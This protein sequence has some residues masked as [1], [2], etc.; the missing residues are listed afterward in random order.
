MTIRSALTTIETK[1]NAKSKTTVR[2]R[3]FFATVICSFVLHCPSVSAA[4]SAAGPRNEKLAEIATMARHNEKCPDIPRQWAV[5]YLILLMMHPP[6]EEQVTIEE[7]KTLA[8]R[9][10][11]G[12]VKW[13]QLYSVE[14]QQAYLI[15]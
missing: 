7:R 13:C 2:P 6:T 15:Y 5:A 9:R 1:P 8:L 14:M 4:E 3:L 11:I 10:E 12:P